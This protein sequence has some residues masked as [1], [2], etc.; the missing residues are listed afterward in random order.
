MSCMI[1]YLLK[2]VMW[3]MNLQ[4]CSFQCPPEDAQNAR[5]FQEITSAKPISICEKNLSLRKYHAPYWRRVEIDHLKDTSSWFCLSVPPTIEE[6]PHNIQL[7]GS[8]VII[9]CKTEARPIADILWWKGGDLGPLREGEQVGC[10][11]IHCYTV[12][13]FG[14]HPFRVSCIL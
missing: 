6:L 14:M 7:R 10:M 3:Y 11:L 4:K 2:N 5:L 8:T 12:N 9:R 1:L 13:S